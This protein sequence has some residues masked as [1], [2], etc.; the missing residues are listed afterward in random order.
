[1][2]EFFGGV[3]F[4][5]VLG[6]CLGS[7]ANVLAIRTHE[8]SSLM[9]RSHCVACQRIIRPRHLIPILSWLVLRGRCA[10]CG[11][12]IH[13]QYPIVEVVATFLVVVTAVRHPPFDGDFILFVSET[14]ILIALLVMV[15]MDIRWQELPLEFMIGVGVLAVFAHLVVTFF[16][17]AS[18]YDLGF[19]LFVA[20]SIPVAFFG[21]QWL[22]SKG[23][24]LGSGD[25]WFGAMMACI[26]GS[27]QLT[28]IAL[29]VAYL[30]G[31]AVAGVLYVSNRVTRG[32]RI[33]F[34]PALAFGLLITLWFGESIQ[35]WISYAF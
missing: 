24:W 30:L 29:Y 8:M 5:A 17:G 10:D 1:M 25:I 32:M 22:I 6:A 33:P 26:L 3:V 34:A 31:G 28:V 2:I 11:A 7:F 14:M 27:W 4:A 20:A 13:I 23:R 15:V 21:L 9:G 35:T 18:L 19:A 12:R 16:H